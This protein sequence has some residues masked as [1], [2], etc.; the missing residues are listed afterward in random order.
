M[1]G[2]DKIIADIHE[3]AQNQSSEIIAIAKKKADDYLK[4]EDA[5]VTAECEKLLNRAKAN[6]E[7]ADNMAE[8]SG[9]MLLK[10]GVLSAKVKIIDDTIKSAVE[11]ILF[12]PDSDYFE[13]VS[14]VV[15]NNA[16]K[17]KGY[18][19][20]NEKDKNRLPADFVENLNRKL[21]EGAS[22]ELC[23]EKADISG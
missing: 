11:K 18:I 4:A 14:K 2:L 9:E 8:A 19:R 5:R 1:S 3:N 13:A 21:A 17:K 7:Y 12:L 22:L 23:S 10:Q 16:Q 15:I 6:S 20:F